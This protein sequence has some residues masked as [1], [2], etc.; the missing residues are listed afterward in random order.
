VFER[1]YNPSDFDEILVSDPQPAGPSS[2]GP[3]RLPSEPLEPGRRDTTLWTFGRSLRVKGMSRDEIAIALQIAND[4][5]RP[6]KTAAQVDAIVTKVMK[7]KDRPSFNGP[8]VEVDPKPA[9]APLISESTPAESAA[10]SPAALGTTSPEL[11]ALLRETVVAVRRFVVM[12][13]AQLEL[14]VLWV[15]LT[16]VVEAFEIVPYVHITA[17]TKRA[18]KSRLLEVLHHLVRRPW[19]TART[20][21]AALSR[22]LSKDQPTLLLD[23]ADAVFSEKS[24][25]AVTLTGVLNAGFSRHL[26]VA[27]C[28]VTKAGITLQ[29]LSPFG[30]K[31]LAGIG[32]LPSTIA[33]RSIPI[34]LRRKLKTERTERARDRVVRAVMAPLGQRF[35][36][37]APLAVAALRHARPILPEELDDRAQDMLEPLLALADLAGDEWPDRV[38]RAAVQLMRGRDRDDDVPTQLLSDIRELLPLGEGQPAKQGDVRLEA[39]EGLLLTSTL[40]PALEKREDRPWATWSR[41]GLMTAHA[42]ARELKK[43][44]VEPCQKWSKALDKAVR[45]Y[46]VADLEEACL[47]FLPPMGEPGEARDVNETG[48]KRDFSGRE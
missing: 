25:Y 45:G 47:R 4:R 33:D 10:P 37:W 8:V 46:A 24:D 42:L 13:P 2:S 38:R 7:A 30:P 9:Q 20:T 3:Y 14:L 36:A 6:P 1:R 41:G 48:A 44:E 35:D 43:F 32:S 22:T 12:S 27:V 40:L 39:R 34:R 15:A 11:A 21:V 17:G 28:E 26:T 23:E 31:A 29:Q 19:L 18:G 16:Y 5:C